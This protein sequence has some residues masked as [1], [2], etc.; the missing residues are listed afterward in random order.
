MTPM[1]H[2]DAMP[3]GSLANDHE[4]ATGDEAG[5]GAGDR[6]RGQTLSVVLTLLALFVVA[7]AWFAY[8]ALNRPLAVEADRSE[9]LAVEAQLERISGEVRPIAAALTSQTAT[10]VAGVIDVRAYRQGIESLRH[11]VDATNDIA[12]TSPEALE[13][14]DI[15][16]TGGS[17][18]VTGMTQALDALAADESSATVAAGA[19]VE[20]GLANL[21]SARTKLDIL[22]GDLQRS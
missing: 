13:I 1:E 2:G 18:I 17:Q 21:E 6:P 4:S 7:G 9:L 22:L 3:K 8:D 5:V 16:L 14:R 20:E 11:L 15:V 19:Q 10:G 12:A